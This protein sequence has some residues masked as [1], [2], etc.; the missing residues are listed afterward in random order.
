M[1]G[2]ARGDDIPAKCAFDPTSLSPAAARDAKAINNDNDDEDGTDIDV[3]MG[4]SPTADKSNEG[5]RDGGMLMAATAYDASEV[6]RP[7]IVGG[8]GRGGGISQSALL[9]STFWR[10]PKQMLIVK[11]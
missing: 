6:P 5:N 10:D 9:Q 4:I 8:D 2:T 3:A 7:K 1:R 11:F